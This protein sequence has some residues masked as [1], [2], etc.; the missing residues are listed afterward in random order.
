[1]LRKYGIN[2]NRLFLLLIALTIAIA[3]SSC[4]FNSMYYHPTQLPPNVEQLEL[5]RGN[6]SIYVEFSEEKVEF[7]DSLWHPLPSDFEIENIYFKSESGNLLNAWLVKSKN[8]IPKATILHLHG[9]SGCL[10][11]QFGAIYHLAN[12]G[13]QILMF[14]YS[15][16]GLSEG[17]ATRKNML[18]DA[19]AALSYLLNRSDINKK[20]ILIYGQSI[21]GHLAV[22]LTEK[23]QTDI[24]ALVIEGAFTSHKDIAV[25]KGG[26]LGKIAKGF[27]RER[28]S[29]KRSI[30][31]IH[32]PTLII[33]STEDEMIPFAMGEELFELANS[34]KDMYV[35]NQCHICGP[36][37]Y[38]DEISD[39]IF[40]MLE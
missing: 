15:G 8:Q 33:H 35:I 20:N 12:H 13:F 23:C 18:L 21:G 10:V 25:V 27:V 26:W 6:S 19:N 39:K 34:P 9:N 38:A 29:A 14:D 30:Q 22:A 11:S 40:E 36:K 7:T 3:V 16:F 32:I 5:N 1:M 2:M 37:Y 4:S 17:K 31:N 28:Y 24:S